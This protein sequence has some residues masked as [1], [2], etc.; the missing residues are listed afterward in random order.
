MA[1]NE[2]EGNDLVDID[3]RVGALEAAFKEFQDEQRVQLQLIQTTLAGLTLNGD[4]R[5]P[6]GVADRARGIARGAFAARQNHRRPMRRHPDSD[7]DTEDSDVA[8]S[9]E[10]LP[11]RR[12]ENR[13]D[14]R[15]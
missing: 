4:N 1:T 9:V 6:E 15:R 5:R 3:R 13:E 14:Y 7:D 11:A 12:Q 8:D 2:G 10:D